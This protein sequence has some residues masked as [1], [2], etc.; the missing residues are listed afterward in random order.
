VPRVSIS[1]SSDV[2]APVTS[3][4][5][6]SFQTSPT[7]STNDT[8]RT[9]LAGNAEHVDDE[10]H[11][12]SSLLPQQRPTSKDIG[13][14]SESTPRRSILRKIAGD[15]PNSVV[16][17]GNS[18]NND[19]N[20]SPPVRRKSNIKFDLTDHN[21]RAAMLL[22]TQMTHSEIGAKVRN[23][24]KHTFAE[25]EILK[26][27]KMIVRVDLANKKSLPP[28]YDENTGQG[29]E[30]KTMAKFREFVVVCRKSDKIDGAKFVLQVYKTRVI[31]ALEGGRSS[32]P[33]YEIPLDSQLS[34]LN[35]YSSLDKSLVLWMNAVNT[36]G[37]RKGT[38]IFI[39]QCRATS[40]SVEWL[41]FIN[42][43]LGQSRPKDLVV[44]VPEVRVSLRIQ[45]PFESLTI[46]ES[47]D[48]DRDADEILQRSLAKEETVAQSLINRSLHMMEQDTE[49][50][51]AIHQWSSGQPIGL[52]WKRYDRLEWVH[53]V[54]EKRMFGTL[55][56]LNSHD[57]E[58]RP[59]E[60]YPTTAMTRKGKVLTEP[61]PVEGFLIRLTSQ[62]GHHRR[63]G[64]VYST[65]LYFSSHDQYLFF[66]HPSKAL[67]PL[68][69]KS[70]LRGDKHDVPIIYK[71][72]PYP[73]KDD[74]IEWL[75][76]P[77]SRGT[78]VYDDEAFEEAKRKINLVENSDGFIDLT[79]VVKVRKL[80]RESLPTEFR[81]EE[82]PDSGAEESSAEETDSETVTVDDKKCFE[83]VL[84]NGLVIRFKA[85]DEQTKKEWKK[86]LRKLAKYWRW[87]HRQDIRTLTDVRE[88][89]IEELQVDEE[90]EARAGQFARK[91][92]LSQTYASP[93]LFNMCGISCCRT[94]H[95]SGPMYSKPR[96]HGT[97]SLNHCI[98]IPGSLLLFQDALRTFTGKIIPH[99]HHERVHKI[100]LTN[101]YLYSGLLTEGDLLYHNRTFDS[102]APG[103]HALPR[104]WL[105]DGW[106]NFDEDVMTC[107][108]LWRPSGKSWFRDIGEGQRARLRRVSAL[109]KKGN[110]VVFRARS[111]A[112]RD[113]WVVA[114]AAEI[115]RLGQGDEFRIVGE[116]KD[117]TKSG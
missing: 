47:G 73:L 101:C 2:I 70:P 49:L 13:S 14:A 100:D 15:R 102:D 59:K 20:D 6:T 63:L 83:L 50:H 60:H 91:W 79:T 31:P 69:P 113:M 114:I 7:L 98:L 35:M 85:Y 81:I 40:S 16:T 37:N 22:R 38:E 109:G 67:P 52:A 5:S 92:E 46:Q 66:S 96:L 56:M 74:N 18:Q 53:G 76:E 36:K 78:E 27:E 115:E 112:E 80:H 24:F 107:F 44:N 39:L 17:E 28:D 61:Q 77:G 84:S 104:I 57:L 97:F 58:L 62:S 88:Q 42:G 110:R 33:K 19:E 51:D 71:V 1:A 111:R 48:E 12:R 117:Q 30:S 10:V 103:H 68:P 93:A 41:T 106:D 99:I 4:V 55:A 43:M 34:K 116:A 8:F 21:T 89:N 3:L 94:I 45:D 87:R 75:E 105:A 23:A 25:G 54:N 26:M 64:R 72:D 86:R 9:S 90:G 82:E 65:R 108:V 11:S 29:V 32:K 95:Q